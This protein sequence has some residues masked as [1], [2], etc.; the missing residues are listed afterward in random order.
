MENTL[1]FWDEN[2]NAIIHIVADSNLDSNDLDKMFSGACSGILKKNGH[3]ADNTS[4]E[5][6]KIEF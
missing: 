2:G 5:N 4:E 6:C 1:T 3:E